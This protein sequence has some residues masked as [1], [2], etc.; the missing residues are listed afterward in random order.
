ML[1]SL[2]FPYMVILYGT[3]IIQYIK[4]K[5]LLPLSVHPG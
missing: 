2:P 3:D 1:F 5:N 4:S